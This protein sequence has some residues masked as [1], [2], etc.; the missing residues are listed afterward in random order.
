MKGLVCHDVLVKYQRFALREKS[1]ADVDDSGGAGGIS[2]EKTS[3]YWKKR[4]QKILWCPGV[5]CKAKVY[6]RKAP[7]CGRH[8]LVCQNCGLKICSQCGDWAH[9]DLPCGEQAAELAE[10]M[11]ESLKLSQAAVDEWMKLCGGK[12]KGCPKCRSLI[13]RTEGCSHMR[14]KCGYQF[15]FVCLTPTTRTHC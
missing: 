12:V 1:G 11:F 10:K 5:D 9:A 15:C 13:E 14:C 7:G 3:N 6:P 8:E 2:E 4:K